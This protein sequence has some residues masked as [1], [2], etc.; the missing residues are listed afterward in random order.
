MQ[1]LL[2][3]RR[4][5]PAFLETGQVD[6][7]W[8]AAR[9]ETRLFLRP[10]DFAPYLAARVPGLAGR[11]GRVFVW[12]RDDFDFGECELHETLV[13]MDGWTEGG[14]VHQ[15]DALVVEAL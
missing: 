3:P 1:I 7:V 15:I 13:P 8:E 6:G 12:W 11:V 10:A 5:M 9:D 4:D 2:V 14:W